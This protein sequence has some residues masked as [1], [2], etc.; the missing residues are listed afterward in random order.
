M[1]ILEFGFDGTSDNPHLPHR[2]PT[3]CLAY[4]GT[5]DNDTVAGWWASLDSQQRAEVAAYYQVDPRADTGRIV[6][7]LI[8]AAMGSRADVAVFPMQ[9]LLVLDS[10]ARMND[11]SVFVGNWSWRMPPEGLSGE[12]AASLRRLA[13]R[14]GRVG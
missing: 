11:P 3:A 9:D 4:T 12:L 13:Q 10:R 7:S 2:F 5:H 6:W 14:Y 8:E 1:R